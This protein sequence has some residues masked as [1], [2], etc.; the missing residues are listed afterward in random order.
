MTLSKSWE[1]LISI[2]NQGTISTRNHNGESLKGLGQR[3]ALLQFPDEELRT[4]I[5]WLIS[6]SIFC[7]EKPSSGKVGLRS[8]STK[9]CVGEEAPLWMISLPCITLLL[10][11]LKICHLCLLASCGVWGWSIGHCAVHLDWSVAPVVAGV[12][13]TSPRGMTIM[14]VT[15][16]AGHDSCCHAV[17]RVVAPETL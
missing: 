17:L 9:Q 14:V 10:I 11:L 5:E 6:I 4:F 13:V 1:K 7:L 12:L 2:V 8:K 15:I 16:I 3:Q